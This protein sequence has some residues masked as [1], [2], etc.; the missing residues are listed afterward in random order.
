M[1]INLQATARLNNKPYLKA[2]A[3]VRAGTASL[4]TAQVSGAKA[5]AHAVD[6]VAKARMSEAQVYKQS[7]AAAKQQ[8]AEQ[9]R[10]NAAV[11]QGIQGQ[12]YLYGDLARMSA[13]AALGLSALPAAALVAGVAWEKGFADVVRTADPDVAASRLQVER[14]RG[15]LVDLVQSVPTS[16]GEATEIATL[17]NQMGVASSQT[18]SFTASVAMFSA[19]SNVSVDQTATAFGRLNS[20]VKD[21][22]GDYNSLADSILKVG[23]NS[24]ATESEIINIATQI[25]SIAGGV[26]FTSKQ[27]VGLS[28]ALASVRVPPELSRGVVTRVFGQISRAVS[29]GGA[30]LDGFAKVS[31]MS[32]E[33]FAK[34]W[35]TDGQAGNAFRSFVNGLRELGPA[36]ES[37]L[38]GLGIT[39]VR[40]VPV[41]LR[42]A[43]AAD[44]EGVV[45]GLLAQT[46]RDAENAAGETQRQYTIM[47]DTVAAKLK[48]A[49]NNVMA[50]FDGMSRSSIGPLG[51]ILDFVSD[52][53][54]DLTN[55]LDEPAKLLGSIQ[56]PMTNSELIG[57]VASAG[58]ATAALLALGSAFFKIREV[59]AGVQ[60][61]WANMAGGKGARGGDPTGIARV[62]GQWGRFPV[63]LQ[64]IMDRSVRTVQKGTAQ[65][66]AYNMRFMQSLT[67]TDRNQ[68]VFARPGNHREVVSTSR[69]VVGEYQKIREQ[70]SRTA[71]S[72]SNSFS[73]M[74]AGVAAVGRGMGAAASFAFGP[75]GLIIGLVTA[76]VATLI[77]STRTAATTSSDLA[78]QMAKLGDSAKGLEALR[79]VEVGG[80]FG[81]SSKP[82]ENGFKSLRS[83]QIE[84]DNLAKEQN[85]NAE[86]YDPLGEGTMGVLAVQAGQEKKA[87]E[88][89]RAAYKIVDEAFLE[90]YNAGNGAKGALTLQ[91]FTGSSR[92]LLSLLTSGSAENAKGYF[93]DLFRDS[94]LALTADNLDKLARGQ[95]PEVRAQMLGLA[96]DVAVTDA[97]LENFEGGEEAFTAMAKGLEEVAK[98]F[99]DYKSAVAEASAENDMFDMSKFSEVLQQQMDAQNNWATNLSTAARL[100]GSEFVGALIDMGTDA[101]APLQ[102]IIDNF[103]ATGGA[104]DGDWAVW[105]DQIIASTKTGSEQAAA[106]VGAAYDNIRSRFQ[107]DSLTD[108]L[109]KMLSPEQLQNFSAS[110]ENLGLESARKYAEGITSG[111]MSVA[112]ALAS[113]ALENEAKINLGFNITPAQLDLQAM[114]ALANGSISTMLLDA[115]PDLARNAIWSTVQLA[116]GETGIIQVDAETGEAIDG[117]AYVSDQA[118]GTVAVVQVTADDTAAIGVLNALNG[119]ITYSDHII[120]VAEETIGR[121]IA[122][123]RWG[124]GPTM[125]NGGTIDYYAN[126]GVR[127]NHVAQIAPAG[128][129][130]TWAEPETGGEGYI[131]LAPSKR[132]RSTAILSEIANR[133]GMSLVNGS[134]AARFADG[135]T[136]EL[137]S[138]SRHAIMNNAVTGSN[139]DFSI[140]NVT[141]TSGEQQDQFREFSRTVRRVSRS[142][143]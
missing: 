95:L 73:R 2:L 139:G 37:E 16:W 104:V 93:E 142:R 137:Q 67:P 133:F 4:N 81:A 9:G 49:G 40:D 41:M 99:I 21:V 59:M 115:A 119:R 112:E 45:G 51:D 22:N 38:R 42:L 57:W 126:G 47:A 39:S 65:M 15:S 117:L 102:A 74:G 85:K 28:G 77:E 114:E 134:E 97:E 63:Q 8:V 12:R 135:G 118:T 43:N 3:E 50:F 125:A 24:V 86:K 52:S 91:K 17:A 113:M 105:M 138:R 60:Q 72:V 122:R 69:V 58:L 132:K 46:M 13:R 106:S 79:N 84:M 10:L 141:F 61:G 83:L 20:I 27:I 29:S 66:R 98:G 62:A 123:D 32:A 68:M 94:G 19:T 64:G 129:M 116:N 36:A 78:T 124:G 143:R 44:S 136:Y 23:V 87:S 92:E 111:S 35:R 5:T 30:S 18:A 48:V 88:D 140:G 6:G 75:W 100:G 107:D 96:G 11:R 128:S 80:L 82:L 90:M 110:M 54:K 53:L 76:G 14:L 127:E 7:T 109:A 26:G 108:P 103:N 89:L 71:E 34:S 25:S 131:P 56:L 130:R 55:S 120:R 33:E 101:Q 70:G 121:P 1:A 31:G